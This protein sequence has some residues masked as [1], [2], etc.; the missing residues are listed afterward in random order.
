MLVVNGIDAGDLYDGPSL[1]TARRQFVGG[2][3]A[4]S[5]TAWFNAPAN[6]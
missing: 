6:W 3:H 1:L 4:A 2:V 5:S